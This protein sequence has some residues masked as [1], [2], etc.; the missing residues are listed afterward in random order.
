MG[1]VDSSLCFSHEKSSNA[2]MLSKWMLKVSHSLWTEKGPSCA[3][4]RAGELLTG[5]QRRSCQETVF[6]AGTV[7]RSGERALL[8]NSSWT[9]TASNAALAISPASGEAFPPASS[10]IEFTEVVEVP[11]DCQDGDFATTLE[12]RKKPTMTFANAL[13]PT[14]AKISN[15]SA[16]AED[17]VPADVTGRRVHDGPS[18]CAG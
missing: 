5:R 4:Q 15:Y 16:R 18:Y 1:P 3:L 6:L 10:S 14:G 2:P 8:L 12:G 13:I 17:F 9:R 11:R 7:G